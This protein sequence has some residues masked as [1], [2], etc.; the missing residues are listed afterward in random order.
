ML[1]GALA[2]SV[3]RNGLAAAMQFVFISEQAFQTD[4]PASMKLAIADS[5]FSAK[6]IAEAIGKAG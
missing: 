6:A 4:R 2:L 1:E 5:Q 3:V